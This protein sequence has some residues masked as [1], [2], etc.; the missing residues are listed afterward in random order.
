[1]SC[2]IFTRLTSTTV[3][4][5]LSTKHLQSPGCNSEL[6]ATHKRMFP[7]LP[8]WPLMFVCWLVNIRLGCRGVQRV[9]GAARHA[10]QGPARPKPV[11][12]DGGVHWTTSQIK[13]CVLLMPIQLF[14]P[15]NELGETVSLFKVSLGLRVINQFVVCPVVGRSVLHPRARN[16]TSNNTVKQNYRLNVS[17]IRLDLLWI[18]IIS[19]GLIQNFKLMHLWKVYPLDGSFL[20]A[21]WI[22]R[23]YICN[24]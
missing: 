23:S 2:A 6:N 18:T 7:P 11:V 21:A 5:L 8:F 4:S 19:K 15:F 12:L 3:S 10:E 24:L 13:T 16:L 9:A 14:H 17:S 22:H 1:M 20:Y